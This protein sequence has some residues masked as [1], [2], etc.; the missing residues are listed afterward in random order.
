MGQM[1][2]IVAGV[3]TAEKRGQQ[4]QMQTKYIKKILEWDNRNNSQKIF[5]TPT[6][7]PVSPKMK[8]KYKIHQTEW[9]SK[10]INSSDDK[11]ENGSRRFVALYFVLKESLVGLR[12]VLVAFKEMLNC[13]ENLCP[14]IFQNKIKVVYC[15]QVNPIHTIEAYTCNCSFVLDQ[16]NLNPANINFWLK[17]TF[18]IGIHSR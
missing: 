17:G 4:D 18:F 8:N 3:G 2:D 9:F 15:K 1:P 12:P 14:Y 10:K 13:N 7:L 16:R 6:R 11:R 5:I